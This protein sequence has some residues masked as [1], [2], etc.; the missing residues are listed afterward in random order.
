MCDSGQGE[1]Y[2]MLNKSLMQILAKVIRPPP[3]A[4]CITRP[5]SSI[6]TLTLRAAIREPAKK[7]ALA[8]SMIGL[9]PQMSLNFPHVGVDADAARR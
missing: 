2:L 5:V 6:W 4:P 3:P 1:F 9:R 8:T 7:N